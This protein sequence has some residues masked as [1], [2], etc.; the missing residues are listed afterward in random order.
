MGALPAAQGYIASMGY[1]L[2]YTFPND[3]TGGASNKNYCDHFWRQTVTDDNGLDGWYQLLSCV[4]S[5]DAEYAG[6]RGANALNRGANTRTNFGLS[7]MP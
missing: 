4:C 7:L 1:G 2:G 3:T 6:V 5:V